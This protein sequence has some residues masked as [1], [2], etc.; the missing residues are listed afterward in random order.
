MASQFGLLPDKGGTGSISDNDATFLWGDGSKLEEEVVE[1]MMMIFGSIEESLDK[2]S[3][4]S[5]F[6]FPNLGQY[7]TTALQTQLVER[8][9][10]DDQ[11]LC[12]VAASYLQ[13]YGRLQASIDGAPTWQMT[14]VDQN[15]QYRECQGEQTVT[16]ARGNTYQ[17]LL[18][19]MGEN[20]M[21]RVKLGERVTKLRHGEHLQNV[22]VQTSKTVYQCEFVV[23]TLSLGVLKAEGEMFDP[24]LSGKKM[25][26]IKK[27]GFGTIAKI[28]IEFPVEIAKVLPDVKPAGFNFLRRDEGLS[29]LE[30]TPSTPW[31]EGVFGLYPDQSDPHLLVAWLT[32][33]A[34]IQVETL[35][36]AQVLA[37][38]SGL[39]SA[40][41]SP[42]IPLLPLPISTRVTTWGGNHLTRGSYSYL[43]PST[44]PNSPAILAEPVGRVLWAGEATHSTYFSTVHGAVESGRREAVRILNWG[45]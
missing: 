23:V 17:G 40:T 44:P 38:I 6:R 4:S 43:T 37:D 24:P 35:L 15:L 42:S 30:N 41:L 16:L 28:F 2:E 26:V 27:M 34:A 20:I 9:L 21:D 31:L 8:G 45:E 22:E 39:I 19:R 7:Y 10:S 11:E 36:P 33:P 25:E 5:L 1:Q 18:E 14:A 12:A 29:A 32:G 3:P 13:W